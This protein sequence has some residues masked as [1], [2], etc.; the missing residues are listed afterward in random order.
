MQASIPRGKKHLKAHE[1]DDIPTPNFD[2]SFAIEL[3]RSNVIYEYIKHASIL[4][5]LL[6]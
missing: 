5:Y 3:H 2:D 4:T 1:A 6:S